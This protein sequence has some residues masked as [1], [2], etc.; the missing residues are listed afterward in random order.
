MRGKIHLFITVCFVAVLLLAGCHTSKPVARHPSAPHAA[1]K[2][3]A[4]KTTRQPKFIDNVYMDHHNKTGA[5]A[6]AIQ[7]KKTPVKPKVQANTE[8]ETAIASTEPKAVFLKETYTPKDIR[9]AHETYP[10]ERNNRLCKKYAEILE[11]KPRDIE[12]EYLYRF[13]DKWY[14][15]NYRL[16][17]CDK[18]GIDCSGFVQRLYDEVYGVDLL[19]TSV[20]QFQNCQRIKHSKDA[21]E[22]DLVFFRINKSKRISHVGV[23]LMNDFFVHASVS[24]GVIISNLNEDYYHATFAGIGRIPRGE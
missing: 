6:Y 8:H 16:G 7:P 14:G 2:P 20:E 15:A 13:I 22:G 4:R 12:N 17:G 3:V 1:P 24:N 9:P 21:R 5:T 19:R 23:Y 18:A 11:V 10:D